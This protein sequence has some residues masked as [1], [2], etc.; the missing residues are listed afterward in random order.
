MTKNIQLLVISHSFLKKINTSLYSVLKHKHNIEL[1]LISPKS[2]YENNKV[3]QPDY[4]NDELDLDITFKE[5]LFNHLRFKIYKDLI[6][7]IRRQNIKNIILDMD[8]LSL[9]SII[10][11]FYSFYFNYKVSYFSNENNILL[12]KKF[13]KKLS[14]KIINF[15]FKSKIQ[16]IFCYTNQ[17][18][19]N[20]NFC[21]L[22]DKTLVI[23]L[24]FN[25]KV[26]N[27]TLR[28]KNSNFVISYFGKIEKKKGIHTLL[29]A[30][31]LLDIKDWVLN[32]D[33]FDIENLNYYKSIKNDLKYLKKTGRLRLIKCNHGDINTFMQKTDLTIVP[34]EWN[35]Q[36]G[37]VIQEAAACGSIV[38]GSKIGAI[39]EILMQDSFIFEPKNANS[40]KN[41]I[42]DIY[43]NFSAY[44]EKFFFTE[45]YIN[46][47]RSIDT[48]AIIIKKAFIN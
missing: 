42:Q 12:E 10:L 43:Y 44:R 25:N 1:K 22:K 17:I 30:L 23:P 15:I 39:P 33:I 13:I 32:L 31:K 3:I 36:Y 37:R 47:N 24:G 46:N 6:G 38:I 41:K 35:E 20:L 21:G 2:H 14:Y 48:Q 29:K 28:N 40:L 45:N 16:K 8:L 26:F 19:D 7:S 11:L 5:T 27:R 4:K 34:S 9:Q 18:K